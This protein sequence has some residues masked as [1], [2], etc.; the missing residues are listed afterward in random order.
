MEVS[1][2]PF[3]L[4]SHVCPI[5]FYTERASVAIASTNTVGVNKWDLVRKKPF[6]PFSN[7]WSAIVLSYAQEMFEPG[8]RSFFLPLKNFAR[9]SFRQTTFWREYATLHSGDYIFWQRAVSYVGG[10]F[11]CWIFGNTIRNATPAGTCTVQYSIQQ[12]TVV[13]LLYLCRFKEPFALLKK[14]CDIRHIGNY[15]VRDNQKKVFLGG[16]FCL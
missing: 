9:T 5:K 11:S 7:L 8:S 3:F 10:G 13:V 6:N 16:R 2:W 15:Q 1:I 12:S 4:Q 14:Q